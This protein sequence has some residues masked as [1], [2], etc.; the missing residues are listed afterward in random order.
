MLPFKP[1]LMN[2]VIFLVETAQLIAVLFVNYKGRP[3]QPGLDENKPLLHS[4]GMSC[5]G[6]FVLAYEI[7]PPL[8]SILELVE[9]PTD[10]FRWT[11]ITILAFDVVGALLWDRLMHAIFAR[12]LFLESQSKVDFVTFMRGLLKVLASTISV[13]M[14]LNGSGIMGLGVIFFLYRNGFF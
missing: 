10:S 11:I 13:Y 6:L 12:K 14:L 3:F 4:L 8:N 7:I 9:F 5:I 2:T 1:N